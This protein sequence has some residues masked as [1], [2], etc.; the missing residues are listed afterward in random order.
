MSKSGGYA[1]PTIARETIQG[2]DGPHGVDA[3]YPGMT[4]RQAYKITALR[5]VGIPGGW[6]LNGKKCFSP[7][8]WVSAAA[9]LADAML[10]EDAEFEARK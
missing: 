6:K 7:E 9:N 10:A 1:Y 2:S 5:V 8:D 3:E 4:M